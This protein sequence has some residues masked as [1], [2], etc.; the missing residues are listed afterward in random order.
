MNEELSP[1]ERRARHRSEWEA[2][3]IPA[4]S[5]EWQS[6]ATIA[7]A[8]GA[9]AATV[10]E[11]L[12]DMLKKNLVERRIVTNRAPAPPTRKRRRQRH[13]RRLEAQFR[14]PAGT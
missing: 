3:I 1:D 8:L 11:R 10:H 14:L 2:R 5:A 12:N 6:A 13:V 9:K 7:A 4:L